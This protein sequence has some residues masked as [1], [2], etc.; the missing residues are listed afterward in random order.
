MAFLAGMDFGN[1]NVANIDGDPATDAA[2]AGPC[3]PSSAAAGHPRTDP[4]DPRR[5]APVP[6]PATNPPADASVRTLPTSTA[7]DEDGASTRQRILRL[8]VEEGPVS[9]VQLATDLDLTAAGVR[10]HVAAMLAAGE[11]AEH[12]VPV[13]GRRRGRPA[14]HYVATARGQAA[15]SDA[16]SD[17]AAEAIAFLTRLGGDEALREFARQRV[18]DMHAHHGDAVTRTGDVVERLRILADRLSGDGFAASV[19]PLPGDRAVQLCQGHCPVQAVATRYPQ[20]CEAETALFSD[21][22]G[23]HVQR[24]STLATGGHVCTTHV[25]LTTPRLPRPGADDPAPAATVEETR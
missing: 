15:L 16:Y 13:A 24:L 14:R 7:P 3:R 6:V 25:P 17:L 19:R 8:V 1:E 2:R 10:R 23:V 21:L 22:L 11:V 4:V 5:G 20:L 18:L 9:V 12:D